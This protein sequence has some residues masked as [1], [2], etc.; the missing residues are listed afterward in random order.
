MK[1]SHV[2]IIV[3]VVVVLC[4][5]GVILGLYFG[6]WQSSST[7]NVL[8][9]GG[10][11][12]Y[13]PPPNNGASPSPTAVQPATEYSQYLYA[14]S[15][16]GTQG[17]TLLSVVNT[18]T[19]STVGSTL[20]LGPNTYGNGTSHAIISPDLTKVYV[21]SPSI[22]NTLS[23]VDVTNP[24]TPVVTMN[25]LV[26][27]VLGASNGCVSRDGKWL[28]IA[29]N[30]GAVV[31]YNTITWAYQQI[32][33]PSLSHP[34]QCLLN[35][36]GTMLYVT[37]TTID[38]TYNTYSLSIAVVNVINP[39]TPI[40]LSPIL[41]GTRIA[42]FNG[43]IFDW[44]HDSMVISDD[45]RYL[46]AIPYTVKSAS[47]YHG[48]FMYQVDTLMNNSVSQSTSTLFDDTYA[49]VF[50]IILS[51]NNQYVSATG[52]PGGV[53]TLY[54][55]ATGTDG[56]NPLGTILSSTALTSYVSSVCAVSS[57]GI[58]FVPS[59]GRTANALIPLGA[60][61][62]GVQVAGDINLPASCDS[63]SN[64]RIFD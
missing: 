24:L 50:A 62:N 4:A 32:I 61:N 17:D 25:P 20:D 22:S 7:K 12:P 47:P 14:P 48:A 23:V 18:A 41:L 58:L 38:T 28:Y 52:S 15:S 6:L 46:W 40:I 33:D 64:L 26:V 44:N 37:N 42:G 29:C 21:T 57:N 30:N 2:I 55:F 56:V 59:S 63:L 51:V 34:S 10:P 36:A 31:Q 54:K 13:V 1:V 53:P 16:S 45:G 11:P 43:T 3:A 19:L 8:T 35:P 39:A 9:L 49:G 27:P 5:L 60:N